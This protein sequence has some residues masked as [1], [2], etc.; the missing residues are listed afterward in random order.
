ME[1]MINTQPKSNLI[2][3]DGDDD[4][5]SGIKSQRELDCKYIVYIEKEEI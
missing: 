3:S 5:D 4:V 2:N 1:I